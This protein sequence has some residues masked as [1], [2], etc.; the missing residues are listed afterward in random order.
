[1]ASISHVIHRAT[2]TMLTVCALFVGVAGCPGHKLTITFSWPS[3]SLV[4]IINSGVPAAAVNSGI[5]GWN[6]MNGFYE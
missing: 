3:L 6:A 4:H 1:M 5:S 2:L